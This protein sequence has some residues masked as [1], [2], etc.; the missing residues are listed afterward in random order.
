[1]KKS[2]IMGAALLAAGASQAATIS[3]QSSVPMYS[4]EAK[5][6]TFVDTTGDSVLAFSGSGLTNGSTTV[7]G[8]QFDYKDSAQL[9]AGLTGVG[10]VGLA[11]TTAPGVTSTSFGDGSFSS[12]AAIYNLIAGGTYGATTI[13]M[14]G[15]TIGQEYQLQIFSNDA[16]E[17]RHSDYEIGFSD[18][19]NTLA[20]SITAGTEGRA[21][22]SNRDPVSKLGEASGDSIIGTFIAD[23]TGNQS[24]DINGSTDGSLMNSSSRAQLNGLQIRA[25]PEPATLGLIGAFGGGIFFL[26]RRFMF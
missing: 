13:N 26:R 5:D 20:D 9:N 3:W 11:M 19:V 16:R 12:S 8:V 2:M 7:N 17:G 10:G 22:L 14:T 24:F 21:S 23:A 25:I 4:G 1:M 6:E 18:G 15:L